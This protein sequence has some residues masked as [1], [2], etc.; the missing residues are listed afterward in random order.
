MIEGNWQDEIYITDKDG[1]NKQ[2]LL[3]L[4]KED[5]YLKNTLEKYVL[6]EYSCNLNIINENVEKL[7]A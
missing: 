1:N 2:V 7:F 6:P 3:N 4:N 5:K